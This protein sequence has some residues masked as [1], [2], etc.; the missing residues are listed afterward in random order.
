MAQI[1]FDNNIQ[2][3]SIQCQMEDS[4]SKICQSYANKINCDI[5][6][7]IF[8]Y[9]GEILNQKKTFKEQA[10]SIDISNKEMNVLV[11][12]KEPNDENKSKS[13]PKFE[14]EVENIKIKFNDILNKYLGDRKYAQDKI[15]KWRDAIMKESE[16]YFSSFK[17]EYTIFM[18][19]V[20]MDNSEKKYENNNTLNSYGSKKR[21]KIKYKS[22]YIK[23]K[24]VIV[25]F[26]K[27][28]KRQKLELKDIFEKIKTKFL[29]L[30][31]CREYNVFIEKYYKLFK[32]DFDG[33]INSNQRDLF[34]NY[35]IANNYYIFTAD[36]KIFNKEEKDYF[37]SE[38]IKTDECT[39]YLV[40]AKKQ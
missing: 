4:L 33:L 28:K 34:Y 38:I 8:L 22:D 20:I 10:N 13:D 26:A 23:A 3:V 11:S 35:N 6:K 29:N 18:N 1:I 12:E 9:G 5:H 16:E 30:S 32:D 7:L 21:F 37:L 17:N 39:L 36:F 40:M 25:M 19:L 2:K 14:E 24:I 27:N 31:E 15:N